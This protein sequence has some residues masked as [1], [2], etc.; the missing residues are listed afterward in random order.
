MKYLLLFLFPALFTAQSLVVKNPLRILAL[1]DSYTIGESVP[2]TERWPVQFKDSLA[3]R[4]IVT[5]TLR[6]IATTGWT[7]DDLLSAVSGQDLDDQNYNLVTLLIGVNNQYQGHAFSKYKTGFLALV[8]S[9]IRYAGGAKNQVIIVSIP[10]YAYTPFGQNNSNPTQVSSEIDMYNLYNK[11][12]ADSLKIKYFNITPISRQGLSNTALVAGDGLHPSGL[13]YSQWVK[14]MMQEIDQMIFTGVKKAEKKS[15]TE[16]SITPN[17][18]TDKITI[19][20]QSSS[21]EIA[22]YQI[23]DVT[24][25]TVMSG[26]LRSGTTE[27]ETNNLPAGLYFVKVR[28]NDKQF[29]NRIVK[30]K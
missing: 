1:G 21:G 26:I 28:T 27:A 8:D 24:G 22:G 15:E 3:V 30:T 7:T 13:Q 23:F 14:L 6:V 17:P 16:L 9:A 25:K 18:F 12:V 2:P 29:V 10:D 11:Q 19:E 20:L 4:G 5:Q